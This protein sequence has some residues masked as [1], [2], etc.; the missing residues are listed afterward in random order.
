MALA[1]HMR[2]H[3]PCPGW[4]VHNGDRR[5]TGLGMSESVFVLAGIGA[6]LGL[7]FG[8]LLDQLILAV[9][10]GIVIGGAVGFIQT[11]VTNR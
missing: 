10:L 8:L 5:E 9:V 3:Q 1:D 2:M 4:R 7:L 11:Q 6:A